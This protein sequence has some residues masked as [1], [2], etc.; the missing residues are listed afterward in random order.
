MLM[1][2]QVFEKG[3][4]SPISVKK[5]QEMLL[6]AENAQLS[7][8]LVAHYQRLRASD[9]RM[10]M[11]AA[12]RDSLDNEDILFAISVDSYKSLLNFLLRAFSFEKELIERESLRADH[13]RETKNELTQE[14]QRL[15]SKLLNSKEFTTSLIALVQLLKGE[16]MPADFATR[17]S[18]SERHYLR[19]I[20]RCIS[21]ISKALHSESPDLVRAFDVLFEMQKMFIKHPPENLKQ[22]LPCLADFDFVY[23][24]L[25]DVSDKM[26]ELQP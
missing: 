24:G 6:D 20:M 18:I 13:E 14:A 16:A 15:I 17:L 12:L 25:K 5:V 19:V 21:R 3:H 1:V 26:I 23:R 7:K 11:L 8:P 4:Q 22:D 2:E 10:G 9:E